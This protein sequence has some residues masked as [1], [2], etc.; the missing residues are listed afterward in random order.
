MANNNPLRSVDKAYYGS[1]TPLDLRGTREGRKNA[2]PNP[3]YRQKQNDVAAS[4]N[5]YYA[6]APVPKAVTKEAVK[7]K[8]TVAI[9]AKAQI[10]VE[11]IQA[12]SAGATNIVVRGESADI[13][14]ARAAVDLSVGRGGLTRE[15]ANSFD[16]VVVKLAEKIVQ[17]PVAEPL[18]V[19]VEV[20]AEIDAILSPPVV[21]DKLKKQRKGKQK[22]EVVVEPEED[23]FTDADVA[24]AFGVGPD[25]DSDG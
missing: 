10:L 7:A 6:S 9:D 24:A 21:L 8:K 4:S 1:R 12:F 3:S 16:F 14:K 25:D 11:A 2:P 18:A 20:D 13:T 19:V 17:E 5:K 23:T 22:V 15:Q